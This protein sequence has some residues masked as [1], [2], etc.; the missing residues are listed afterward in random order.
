M[1]LVTVDVDTRLSPVKALKNLLFSS[2]PYNVE[3]FVSPAVRAKLAE[4]LEQE[5]FDVVQME[6]TFVAWYARYWVEPQPGA[7]ANHW[8]Q[9]PPGLTHSMPPRRPTRTR[10]CPDR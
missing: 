7:P 5:A 9:L 4:L 10:R 8:Q 3:R 2:L 1:R 6:G